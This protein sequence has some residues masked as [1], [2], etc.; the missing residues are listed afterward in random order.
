MQADPS[1]TT[2]TLKA[3]TRYRPAIAA[4]QLSV[5]ATASVPTGARG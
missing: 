3:G 2:G 5:E 4:G 1:A